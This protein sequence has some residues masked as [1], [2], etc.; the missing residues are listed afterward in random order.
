MSPAAPVQQRAVATRQQILE[1]AARA[2]ATHGYQG[3]SLNAIIREST[4][5][6]GA[7]YFHFA[8]KE[9][10]ALAT[11]RSKQQELIERLTAEVGDQPDAAS[12]LAAMIRARAR[13]LDLDHSLRCVLTLGADLGARAGPDS[14]YANYQQTAVELLAGLV[15]RGQHEG[16]FRSELD[17]RRA[18]ES[19]FAAIIGSDVLSGILAQGEDLIQRGEDLI[20]L[21]IE[22]LTINR[23]VP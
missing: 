6:K 12:A 14:E 19:L 9:E 10:L 20:E 4:V 22:G 1:I 23:K 18:G 16:V 15:R 17:P 3:V 2:F 21:V 5:T 7:F 11:F 13:L 8:S